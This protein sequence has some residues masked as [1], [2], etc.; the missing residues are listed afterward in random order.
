MAMSSVSAQ[1]SN[2]GD[3]EGSPKQKGLAFIITL[4]VAVA[5][6]AG[7]IAGSVTAW[8]ILR[9]AET[10][11]IVYMQT[12]QITYERE[13]E[14]SAAA[15]YQAVAASV[16]KVLARDDDR[17][18]GIGVGTG[19]IVDGKGHILTNNHVVDQAERLRVQL[20]DGST[21]FAEVVARDPG[22]DLALIRA[23]FPPDTITVARFGDSAAVTPGDPVF[24]IGSPFGYGHSITAGIVSAVGRS[25]VESGR[26]IAGLIQS[27]T[28]INSGNSGGPLLNAYGEVIGIT[29]AI[30]TNNQVFMGVGLSIPSN[31]VQQLLP[32]LMEGGEIRR[33]F[34]GVSMATI[35]PQNARTNNLAIEHGVW[36]RSVTPGSGAAEAGIVGSGSVRRADIITAIDGVPMRKSDDVIAYIQAKDV[37]DTISITLYRDGDTRE[38]SATLGA[39]QGS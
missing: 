39:W 33:A 30:Q 4:C 9:Q 13:S 14:A 26:R 19:I 18:R 12:P 1:A 31:L 10:R 16:V 24:A 8:L 3:S 34:L 23:E 37:G 25:Y 38:V 32:Q 28:Q 35:T 29:T 2:G 21:L 36:V 20:L 11:P 5:V 15:V 27:D 22:T 17:P 7:I 6:L